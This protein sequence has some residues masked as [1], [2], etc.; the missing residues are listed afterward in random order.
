MLQEKSSD[1]YKYQCIF[2]NFVWSFNICLSFFYIISI[3]PSPVLLKYSKSLRLP[4]S[5]LGNYFTWQTGTSRKCPQLQMDVDHTY[6]VLFF[7]FHSQEISGGPSIHNSFPDWF[8]FPPV[9]CSGFH[10]Q[11]YYLLAFPLRL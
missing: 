10:P 6:P 4:L 3:I 7:C 5:T 9:L 11:H 8:L 2:S 1:W